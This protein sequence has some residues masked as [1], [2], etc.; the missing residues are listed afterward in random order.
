MTLAGPC[1]FSSISALVVFL[2]FSSLSFPHISYSYQKCI[3]DRLVLVIKWK[4]MLLK[5]VFVMKYCK[6]HYLE[7]R[8]HLICPYIYQYIQMYTDIQID[9]LPCWFS[10][11][12]STCQC[13]RKKRCGFHPWVR[14]MPWSRKWQPI[15]VFLSEKFHRQRS[16]VGYSPYGS[17]ESDMTEQLS[18]HIDSSRCKIL[19]IF[20]WSFLWVSI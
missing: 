17:K 3:L 19:T 8:W 10:G 9:G 15:P 1:I 7:I 13:K 11:K 12:E 4:I 6:V 5:S 2:D 18:T 20:I 14:Q 16:L